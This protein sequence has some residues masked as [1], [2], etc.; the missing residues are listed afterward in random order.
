MEYA[1]LTKEQQ[2]KQLRAVFGTP[3]SEFKS[4]DIVEMPGWF[5]PTRRQRRLA[6]ILNIYP[7]RGRGYVHLA[8]LKTNRKPSKDR[9]AEIF[10]PINMIQ[11]L[12][13][14]SI[15]SNLFSPFEPIRK[16]PPICSIVAPSSIA[17]ANGV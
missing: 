7:E 1:T 15:H 4:G 12:K 11:S 17:H 5:K 3:A 14:V 10:F 8:S 9:R 6:Q 16:S 13:K 2:E